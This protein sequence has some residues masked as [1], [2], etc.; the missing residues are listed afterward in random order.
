MNYTKSQRE[1]YNEHRNRVIADLGIT[2]NQYNAFRRIGDQLHSLYEQS[3][4]GTIDEQAYEDSTN[5]W[6]AVADRMALQFHLY[7]YYQTDPRGATIYCSKDPIA[8]NSYTN[9]SCIY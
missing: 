7:I 9:A 1:Y 6:Y 2:R 5:V 3:C 8:K 4:N